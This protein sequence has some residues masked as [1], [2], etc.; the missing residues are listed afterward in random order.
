MILSG[1]KAF[2]LYKSFSLALTSAR[3]VSCLVFEDCI[4]LLAKVLFLAIYTSVT[5][6]EEPVCL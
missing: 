6:G 3:N 2:R 1:I 4:L 5:S